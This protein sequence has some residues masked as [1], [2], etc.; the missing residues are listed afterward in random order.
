MSAIVAAVP[1]SA[2]VSIHISYDQSLQAPHV[3][4]L[5]RIKAE[6]EAKIRAEL[7]AE[8][9][10]KEKEVDWDEFSSEDLSTLLEDIHRTLEKRQL[11]GKEPG[12]LV[13][14]TKTS[15]GRIYTKDAVLSNMLQDGEKVFSNE[16]TNNGHCEMRATFVA[17][18]NGFV[19]RAD[20]EAWNT[21]QMKKCTPTVFHTYKK[22][23]RIASPTTLCS[24]F[25]FMI[26]HNKLHH[27]NHS[28]SCGYAKCY[29]KRDGKE[30]KLN[31]LL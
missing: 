17:E 25:R 15:N 1:A 11:I 12:S 10:A 5:A 7:Q 4:E 13:N 16:I 31:Q 23:G 9:D 19:V 2:V 28:T 8:Q 24:Y 18:I 6:M 3:P 14:K 30:I 26:H 20:D 29:V 21:L 22:R 27:R